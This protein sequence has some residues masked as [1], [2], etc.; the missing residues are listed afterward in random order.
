M[1]CEWC[2]VNAG[3]TS[4]KECCVLRRLAQMPQSHL[5]E[6]AKRLTKAEQDELRPKLIEERKRLKEKKSEQAKKKIRA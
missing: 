4:N 1:I 2:E 3:R 5:R 6:Y